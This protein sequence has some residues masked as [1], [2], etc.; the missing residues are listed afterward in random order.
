MF[1]TVLRKKIGSFI[2]GISL[3]IFTKKMDVI[4]VL[5]IVELCK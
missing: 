2:H 3:V 4:D 1:W 5:C